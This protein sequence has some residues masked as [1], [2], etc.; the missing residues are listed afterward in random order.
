[1]TTFWVIVLLVL[2]FSLLEGASCERSEWRVCPD[3]GQ[4]TYQQSR[5]G[6]ASIC[7]NPACLSNQEDCDE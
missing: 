6:F 4:E 3:C 5:F 1:M 7:H 2:L